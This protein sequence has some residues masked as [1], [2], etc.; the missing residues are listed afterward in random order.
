MIFVA[1]ELALFIDHVNIGIVPMTIRTDAT[2]FISSWSIPKV[3]CGGR[4]NLFMIGTTIMMRRIQSVTVAASPS[5][6][7]RIILFL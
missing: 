1:I 6:S 2:A 3:G 4:R 5:T 7:T